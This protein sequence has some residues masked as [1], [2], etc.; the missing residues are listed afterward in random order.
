MS[1]LKS[2]AALTPKIFSPGLAHVLTR[3]T[4][5]NDPASTRDA[6]ALLVFSVA[7]NAL[8]QLPSV[9]VLTADRAGAT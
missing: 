7:V 8:A 1:T 2:F 4:R 9:R 3:R 5:L 6:V